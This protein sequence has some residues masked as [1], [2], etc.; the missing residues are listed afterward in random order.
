MK[1]PLKIPPRH[2]GIIPITTRGH[3][4]KVPVGYFISNQHLNKRLDPSIHVIDG[5]YNST[6]RLTLHALAANY[7]NKHIIFNKG[8]CIGHVEPSIDYMLQT[9]INSLKTQKMIDEHV[10]PDTFTPPLHTL[11]CDVAKS[12]NQLLETFKSQFTQDET[13]IGPLISPKWRLTHM[14]QNLSPTGHI[15]LL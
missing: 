5:I 6:D 1:S 15:P 4:L 12:L 11:P 10:Q 8:K 7:T 9:A 14:T 13:S 2:N 3:N